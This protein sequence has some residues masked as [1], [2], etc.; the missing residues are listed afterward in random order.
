MRRLRFFLCFL[1]CLIL[2]KLTD[3]KFYFLQLFLL[4]S[5]SSFGQFFVSGSV[6]DCENKQKIKGV[7]IEIQGIKQQ[8]ISSENGNFTLTN[9]PKG[10]HILFVSKD[11]FK[12]QHFQIEVKKNIKNFSLAICKDKEVE[13]QEVIVTATR[14]QKNLKNV[15][16]TVQVVTSEDIKKSH[17]I[18]FQSFL[19]NEF[20]GINFSYKGGMPNINMMGFG[21]KYILFL[22]NGERMAGEFFDNIDYD[23]IDVD[24]IE[25]IEIIKGASSSLYGSNALGGVINI[26]TKETHNPLEISTS[27][28]YDSNKEHKINLSVGS[29]QKWGSVSLNSFFKHRKPYI[30]KDSKPT[31]I[32]FDDGQTKQEKLSQMYIAGFT[33]YGINP[34]FKIN[35]LPEK[36]E[37]EISPNYY[38]SERNSGSEFSQK[39][40]D[41]YHNYT[42]NSKL[43]YKIDDTQT[44]SLSG[45]F[46]RYDKFNYY[47]LLKEKEK[48]YENTIW[49]TAL[50]Y[51]LNLLNKHSLVFGA[52]ILSDELLSFRFNKEGTQSKEN[53]KNY[54]IFGQQDWELTSKF[55]LVTGIRLDYHS[56]FK[57][58]FTYRLS[59]MYKLSP[60]IT[61]RGGYSSG[62]RSPTLKELYT[63]WFHP[64]GG[65]FQIM[66]NK[67]LKPETSHNINF[68]TDYNSRK[69]NVTAMA[70][71]SDVKNKIA[72]NWT[73]ANDTIQFVNFGGRTRVIGSEFSASYRLNKSFRFKSSYAYYFIEK[74]K[75]EERPHTLT[76]KAEYLP[77]PDAKYIPNV[78]LSGKWVS[79]TRLFSTDDNN[80]E[81]SIQYEGYAIWRLQT[82]VKLPYGFSASAGVNNLLDYITPTTSFNSSI[83][84]GRTYFVGL[85]WSFQ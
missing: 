35:I 20:S 37:A 2:S 10:K 63:N 1:I 31:E 57:Q 17:S 59:G 47:L 64:W 27:Y 75:S 48:N 82:S 83:S 45:A 41:H 39:V 38:F 4:I 50:Q 8:I 62:F 51:N 78:I 29:G 60:K 33:N 40:R 19:E 25:R 7:S 79:P 73:Q 81:Y 30:L 67:N 9:I 70:Q 28:L 61:F 44:L 12:S 3:M 15:P 52:E 36:L 32:I 23:R 49:R 34:K 42:L 68:S 65:G 22:V 55:T 6:I 56:F 84:P 21:G 58:H 5:F 53:T 11:G 46:D 13:I 24:N 26:I 43:N 76:F 74:R 72:N 66:G 54:T 16:I 69:W 71:L 18:D 14:S 77:D 85:K 80:R